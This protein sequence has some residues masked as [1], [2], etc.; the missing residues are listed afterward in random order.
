MAARNSTANQRNGL[1]A[2]KSNAPRECAANT[3]R[4]F[5]PPR[6]AELKNDCRKA[7]AYVDRADCALATSRRRM[8]QL[9]ALRCAS[10]TP[11]PEKQPLLHLQ[12]PC[13]R[14]RY[15][16]RAILITDPGNTCAPMV[17]L[18]LRSDRPPKHERPLVSRCTPPNGRQ[19]GRQRLPLQRPSHEQM[20]LPS[21]WQHATDSGLSP[22]RRRSSAGRRIA[23]GQLASPVRSKRRGRASKPRRH[24][25]KQ[26]ST[27]RT[28]PTADTASSICK[29]FRSALSDTDRSRRPDGGNVYSTNSSRHFGSSAHA[30]RQRVRCCSEDAATARSG[31]G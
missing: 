15:D 6:Y 13:G 4:I 1:A 29:H 31:S 23:S 18:H 5:P 19:C 28:S 12:Q 17:W 20:R 2:N 14:R 30:L 27:G 22:T 26:S 16:D 21:G 10:A 11:C 7:I 25:S 9:F 3:I 8:I 24:L